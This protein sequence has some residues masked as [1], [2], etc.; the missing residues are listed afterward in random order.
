MRTGSPDNCTNFAKVSVFLL[1]R[2]AS[3]SQERNKSGEGIAALQTRP[4]EKTA[5]TDTVARK[6]G[7]GVVVA[8]VLHRDLVSQ[9]GEEE[10]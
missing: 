5:E 7:S 3:T 1:F 6:W 9:R 4:N 2:T 10:P 8:R